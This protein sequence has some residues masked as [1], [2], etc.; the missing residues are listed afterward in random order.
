MNFPNVLK[1]KNWASFNSH[2]SCV[3]YLKKEKKRKKRRQG[4]DQN[5][6][7]KGF[8]HLSWQFNLICHYPGPAWAVFI[9]LQIWLRLFYYLSHVG[10]IKF[11][12][13]LQYF[14]NIVKKYI[15]TPLSNHHK[16]GYK[17]NL[18]LLQN[19]D[20]EKMSTA[21]SN[22]LHILY[23]PALLPEK[24]LHWLLWWHLIS[25]FLKYSFSSWILYN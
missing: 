2:L 5:G 4:L 1:D 20:L 16:P 21:F 9:S 22:N 8:R 7:H 6:A 10:D 25:C 13:I 23:V 15:D 17:W 24:L 12:V 14:T 19:F 3:V 18:G 11:F